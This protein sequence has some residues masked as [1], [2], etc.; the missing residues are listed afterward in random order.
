MYALNGQQHY[1]TLIKIGC[2]R[3]MPAARSMMWFVLCLVLVKDV[4]LS[5]HLPVSSKWAQNTYIAFC[6]ILELFFLCCC[7]LASDVV[8]QYKTPA[9]LETI[10]RVSRRFMHI[11][12]ALLLVPVGTV[13]VVMLCY[14]VYG[15]LVAPPSDHFFSSGFFMFILYCLSLVFIFQLLL[16]IF[17]LPLIL[18]EKKGP[19]TA[20]F[21]SIKMSYFKVYHLF[22]LYIISIAAY[23]FTSNSTSYGKWLQRH[24]LNIPL[25]WLLLSF[26][27][28][29]LFNLLLVLYQDMKIHYERLEN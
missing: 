1:W 16:I 10:T 12:M 28:A 22:I 7:L 26:L 29:I 15:L 6:Y 3:M 27:L 20:F 11:L 8:L 24:Y 13:F 2:R 9:I 19:I 23:L 18:I 21:A 14:R 5:I 17:T 25:N 4:M